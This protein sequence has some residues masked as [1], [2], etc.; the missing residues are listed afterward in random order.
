[1]RY[2]IREHTE[3]FPV[4]DSNGNTIMLDRECV[5]GQMLPKKQTVYDYSPWCIV[6]TGEQYMT[7]ES[8]DHEDNVYPTGEYHVW[9]GEKQRELLKSIRALFENRLL[10]I[11]YGQIRVWT[12][13]NN[14]AQIPWPQQE[15]K[16]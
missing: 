14:N 13:P 10:P 3:K 6:T 16:K 9:N 8:L 11:Q 7:I 5:S 1:M 4:T 2:I 12:N 15:T